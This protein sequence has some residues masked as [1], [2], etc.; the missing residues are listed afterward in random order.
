MREKLE[1]KIKITRG[2]YNSSLNS[3]ISTN[4]RKDRDKFLMY[5]YRLETYLE[6]LEIL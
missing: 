1:L 4:T 3:F 2:L 5:K 6:I